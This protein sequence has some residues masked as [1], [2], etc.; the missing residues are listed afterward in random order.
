MTM[1]TP[2]SFIR[3]KPSQLSGSSVDA[4]LSF[5]GGGDFSSECGGLHSGRPEFP[6]PK[7]AAVFTMRFEGPAPE[8]AES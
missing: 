1:R 5:F 7:T 6:S 2:S 3:L 4:P 8:E